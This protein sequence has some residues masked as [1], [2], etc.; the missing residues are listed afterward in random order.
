MPTPT[1]ADV[2]AAKKYISS[3]RSEDPLWVQG[4]EV[5]ALAQAFADRV[6]EAAKNRDELLTESHA[7]EK[8]LREQVA[9]LK[10]ENDRLREM[11]INKNQPASEG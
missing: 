4:N 9:A 11:A 1:P 6:A 10:Q 5:T 7:R 3:S 2:A 8:S